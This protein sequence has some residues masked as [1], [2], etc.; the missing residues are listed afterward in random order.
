MRLMLSINVAIVEVA[1]DDSGMIVKSW[2]IDLDISV[3]E[4][5]KDKDDVGFR[6]W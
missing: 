3:L 4:K 2:K 6:I 1:V 5:V